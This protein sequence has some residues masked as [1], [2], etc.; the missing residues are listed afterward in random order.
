MLY[1][2]GIQKDFDGIDF[3]SWVTRRWEIVPSRPVHTDNGKQASVKSK[4]L[5]RL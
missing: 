4:S 5:S 1:Q 2:I 3:T